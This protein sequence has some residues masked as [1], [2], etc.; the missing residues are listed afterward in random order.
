MGLPT[1]AIDFHTIGIG[2]LALLI[3]SLIVGFMVLIQRWHRF[4]RERRETIRRWVMTVGFGAYALFSWNDLV[5][6]SA[7]FSTALLCIFFA[8]TFANYLRYRPKPNPWDH[9]PPATEWPSPWEI[10]STRNRVAASTIVA[11]GLSAG[12]GMLALLALAEW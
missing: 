12:V 8:S 1:A 11:L 9:E 4:S 6:G 3:L 10:A 7:S 5:H 2:L